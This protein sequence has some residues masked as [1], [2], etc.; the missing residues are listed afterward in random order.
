M[1]KYI[2][3]PA[4]ALLM[5]L[6]AFTL[7]AQ[8]T[9]DHEF[10]GDSF[11]IENVLTTGESYHYTASKI[12]ELKPGFSYTAVEG[13]EARFEVLSPA[14]TIEN[15]DFSK[16]ELYPNP[17]GNHINFNIEK[18]AAI[19]ISNIQGITVIER[20]IAKGDNEIDISGL[21]SGMYIYRI[22]DKV[23]KFVKE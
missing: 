15:E 19:R 8:Q 9:Y 16:L 20:N 11:T 18:D 7:E 23:G 10:N 4:M 21:A 2:K 22:G 3:Y 5:L 14:S 17:A 13:K 12:I 6:S 1:K